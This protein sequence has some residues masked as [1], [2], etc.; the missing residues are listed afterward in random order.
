MVFFF[1]ILMGKKEFIAEIKTFKNLIF[2]VIE[3]V[4]H[5]LKTVKTLQSKLRNPK[6]AFVNLITHVWH[7]QFFLM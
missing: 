5:T 2:F 6:K 7:H 4:R 1:V 3:N